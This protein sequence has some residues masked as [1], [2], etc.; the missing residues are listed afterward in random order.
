M[1]QRHATHNPVRQDEGSVWLDAALVIGRQLMQEAQRSDGH[2]SWM[3]D[4]LVSDEAA[5][6]QIIYGNVGP[7]LYSGS[8]GI[9]WFLAQLGAYVG[10]TDLERTGIAALSSALSDC[11][12]RLDSSSLSLFSGASGA[13]LVALQVALRLDRPNLRRN[14]LSLAKATARHAVAGR[15]PDEADLIGGLAGIVV[16]LTAMHRLVPDACFIDACR[17]VC[18]RLVRMRQEDMGGSSWPDVRA[19]A[20]APG[21][22][23]LAHG[24]SG[25]SW[26]L[27]EAAELTGNRQFAEVAMSALCYER[28]WFTPTASNWPDLRDAPPETD[29][30]GWPGSMTAWCHGAIGIGTLRW[31]IYEQSGDLA[32]LAEAGASIHAARTLMARA[33]RA[34]N[35]GQPVD[36]TLCHG[37][38]GAVELL[39]LAYEVTS[40]DEH[41]RAA[42]RVGSLCHEIFLA[43]HGIWTNGLAGAHYVPGLMVGVAG[44]GTMMLRLHNITAIGSPLLP[45]RPPSAAPRL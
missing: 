10:D 34:L 14:A 24:V 1:D 18:D 20:Q 15:L 17:L 7:G 32:A 3:G 36:V 28:S 31:R 16:A 22:C 45:G 23:G 11:K 38:G 26:A 5:T 25:I 9:G 39:L 42:H 44:V 35:E 8:A 4:D 33:R 43:N 27:Y 30:P 21:L 19:G 41:Y 37:L 13:A 29:A 12:T 2:T 6:A 40:L